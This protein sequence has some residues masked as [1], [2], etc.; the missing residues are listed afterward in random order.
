MTLDQPP[1]DFR[2]ATGAERQRA[3]GGAGFTFGR[4]D[5]VHHLGA[6]H[7]EVVNLVVDRINFAAQN[8]ERQIVGHA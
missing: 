8:F 1:Q 2:F 6:L 3:I 5:F 4:A 7:Q